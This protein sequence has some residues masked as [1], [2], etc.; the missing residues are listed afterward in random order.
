VTESAAWGIVMWRTFVLVVLSPCVVSWAPIVERLD[1]LNAQVGQT[2]NKLST[3]NSKLG[4]ANSQID[5]TNARLR[6]LEAKL[7]EANRKLQTVE[8]AIQKIP[9]LQPRQ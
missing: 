3:T 4:T 8:Q 2:N 9:G 7:D 1:L 5:T 6:N